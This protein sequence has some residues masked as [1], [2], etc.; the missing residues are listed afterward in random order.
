M[1][2]MRRG[3]EDR[4]EIESLRDTH[5]SHTATLSLTVTRGAKGLWSTQNTSRRKEV[6]TVETLNGNPENRDPARRGLKYHFISKA[7]RTKD[8]N[9]LPVL[10][11]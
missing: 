7:T 8:G 9:L 4:S 3:D 2:R 1:G 10:R 6:S 5:T 11:Y